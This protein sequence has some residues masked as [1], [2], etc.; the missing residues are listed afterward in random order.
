MLDPEGVGRV[1]FI[2]S[3]A[4]Y[5]VAIAEFG[6]TVYGT[7]EVVKCLNDKAALRRLVSELV[8]LHIISS[9]I[10][11][12]LYGIA[13]FFVWHKINDIRLLLFS[14]SFL[15]INSFACEWYFMGTERFRYITIRSLVTRLL[16]LASVFVLI[17][18]PSDF[19][20]YYVIMV[21]AACANL[22]WNMFSLFR[23]VPLQL[24]GIDW[25]RH[26]KYTW[27]TYVISLLYS[28]TI[29]LDNVLVGLAST[30][31]T[32]AFYS[33]T[34]KIAR[35][36]S[37]LLSDSLLVFF[38][39]M[40]ALLKEEKAEAVQALLLRNVQFITFFAVPLCTGIFLLSD[41]LV[42]TYLG[43]SF[44]G[45]AF[46]L[47]IVAAFPFIKLF[48][49]FITRQVLVAG[50]N[51]KLSVISL[52]TGVVTLLIAMPLLTFYFASPGACI[53]IML[54]EL[55]ILFMNCYFA[56]KINAGLK[57]F[58]MAGFLKSCVAVLVFIPVVYVLRKYTSGVVF[59]A[60]AFVSCF[61]AYILV[62]L[63]VLRTSFALYLNT[64]VLYLFKRKWQ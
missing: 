16:G 42:A 14:V 61:I 35:V 36:S 58:D 30:A 19:Y 7:R 21:V 46:N 63:F 51:E 45:V 15:L 62:Q 55:V 59:L 53:A 54:T 64:T 18:Q 43:K 34:V 47:K 60:S 12:V 37:V 38:P 23:E 56:R 11:M 2:D 13:V 6:I 10:T 31:A 29:M 3:F 32:V 1:G 44:S 22:V 39:K 9:A 4:Y 28:A 50:H 48:S 57:I 25:K 26:V 40:V 17:K 8:V 33:F 41:E 20:L 24:K 49:L 5:F 52:S 27:V